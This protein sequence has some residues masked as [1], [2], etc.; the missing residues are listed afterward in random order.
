MSH[1][2]RCSAHLVLA[3]EILNALPFLIR[4]LMEPAPN[5]H[6]LLPMMPRLLRRQQ[7]LGH[8]TILPHHLHNLSRQLTARR[9]ATVLFLGLLGWA[10]FCEQLQDLGRHVAGVCVCAVAENR[11]YPPVLL[12]R[13]HVAGRD[14]ALMWVDEPER[15]EASVAWLG[16]VLEFEG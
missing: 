13:W 2:I 6:Q 8:N 1:K 11:F 14:D 3:E 9:L 4:L 5:L 16:W 7:P 10:V 12:L 15:D